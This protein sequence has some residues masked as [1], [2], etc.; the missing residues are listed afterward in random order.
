MKLSRIL[1]FVL[2]AALLAGC[3]GQGKTLRPVKVVEVQQVVIESEPEK[4][5][6]VEAETQPE[7]PAEAAEEAP[8]E[9]VVEVA[10]EAETVQPAEEVAAAVEVQPSEAAKEEKVEEEPAMKDGVS[11]EEMF[12]FNPDAFTSEGVEE[13]SES[14]EKK[15]GK[16][17]KKKGVELEFDEELGEVVSRKKH[18]RGDDAWNEEL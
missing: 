5:A 4:P 16:K 9:A 11:L 7:V 6:E 3:G 13:E 12:A 18:K 1:G 17:K 14:G 15:K 8:A 2:L 10:A